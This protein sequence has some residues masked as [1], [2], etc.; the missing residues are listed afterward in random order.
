MKIFLNKNPVDLLNWIFFS[1]E[2]KLNLSMKKHK[3][4][5]F[6]SEENI[7][8]TRMILAE[9]LFHR[10]T[11]ERSVNFCNSVSC[12]GSFEFS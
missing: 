7:A 9:N 11:C 6:S 5:N 12:S 8:F 3:I 4:R 1:N 10:N 2:L